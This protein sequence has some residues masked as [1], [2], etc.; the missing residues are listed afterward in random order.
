MF[1]AKAVDGLLDYCTEQGL[2]LVLCTTGLSEE[3]LD[4]I[5][6]KNFLRVWREQ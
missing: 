1:S 5:W 3:Q 2:P 4:K 6:Y